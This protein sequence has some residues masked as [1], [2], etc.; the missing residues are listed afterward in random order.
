MSHHISKREIHEHDKVI[1]GL[2]ALP[3]VAGVAFAAPAKQT[4]GK[5]LAKQ[6]TQFSGKA[7]G[8]GHSG[9]GLLRNEHHQSN[10]ELHID[11]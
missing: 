7:N 3:L 1:Y 5:A 6:P 4:E 11:R 2:A 10:A 8:Q 9:V